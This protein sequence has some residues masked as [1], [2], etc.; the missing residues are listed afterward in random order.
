M[1]IPALLH[2]LRDRDAPMADF[3]SNPVEKAGYRL[4]FQDEF[5]GG[6]PT[7]GRWLP[8]HL[9]QW[10]SRERARARTASDGEHLVLRIDADQP[11]WCPEFDGRVR[12][13][14]LQTGVL[15]GPLGSTVGQ[16]R[17]NPACVVR[18]AQER[19][20]TCAPRHGWIEV[21]MRGPR[22]AGNHAALWMIGTEEEPSHC[23][24]IC[25]CELFGV[26]RGPAASIVRF[27]VHPFRDPAIV[28]DFHARTLPIDTAEF[29]VYAA[30]WTPESVRFFVDN[31]LVGSVGQSPRY[32]M[33]LMLGLYELPDRTPPGDAYPKHCAIDYVRVYRPIGG[34]A[35]A[36]R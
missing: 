13:S 24:E 30:D 9:P 12:V 5:P 34:D 36:A 11:A 28:D 4:E 1:N 17:F 22:T 10:S 6:R 35:D 16:H 29:H 32:R 14:S 15:S 26:D 33:Q 31:E 19:R 2:S 27:G 7:E 18:E 3:P 8:W 25:I 20:F 21:R 23:A